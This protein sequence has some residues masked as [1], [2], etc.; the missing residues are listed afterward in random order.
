MRLLELGL[1]DLGVEILVLLF[2]LLLQVVS[3]LL[4][5]AVL[6]ADEGQ[7]TLLLHA[8][9]DLHSQFSLVF[10]FDRLDILP[11]LVFDL[12][13]VLLVIFDHLLDLLGQ[14]LFLRIEIL[15]FKHLVSTQLLHQA[16]V[17]QIRLTHEVLKLVQVLLLQRLE[18]LVAIHVRLALLLLVARLRLKQL[19]VRLHLVVDFLLVASLHITS[20]LLNLLHSLPA[21]CFLLL[22]F[23]A[24]V[25]GLLF[26][27]EHES[28]LAFL[29]VSL[30]SLDRLLQVPNLLLQFVSLLLL[31]QDLVRRV[32][33][34]ALVVRSASHDLEHG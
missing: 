14:R 25:L 21:F 2:D 16:L 31:D 10:L 12:L 33:Q 15:I 27:L 18:F 24:Q 34:F 7:L 19:S 23:A 1:G 13:S 8:L 11:S 26:I 5:V 32:W 28:C 30:L 29:P 4:I 20:V 17:G 3:L 22:H 6:I 9:V